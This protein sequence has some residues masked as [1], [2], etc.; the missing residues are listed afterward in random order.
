MS[1]RRRR[2]TVNEQTTRAVVEPRRPKPNRGDVM[3]IAQ[4]QLE[5]SSCEFNDWRELAARENDGLEVTLTW[6]KSADQVRI[7]VSDLKSD[8]Q[9]TLDAAGAD[10]LTAYYH[11]FAFTADRDACLGEPTRESGIESRS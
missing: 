10:A 1:S 5:P 8:S 6:S 3:T 2:G 7:N 4:N 11:P 9:L